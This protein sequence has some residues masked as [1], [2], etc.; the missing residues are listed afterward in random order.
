MLNIVCLRAGEAFAPAYVT[1][2]FDSVQRNLAKGFPYR[3][4]CF[5]D[6]PDE[7]PNH[8]ETAPLPADLP[9]WWSKLGLF[10]AGLFP[11]GDRILYLDLDTV[12]TGRLDEIAAYDGPFA[13][14]RDFYRPDGL[15]S[16]VMAWKAGIAADIWTKYEAAGC[17]TDDKDGDQA[18]IERRFFESVLT[19]E[20]RD[21]IPHRLQD[22][23]PGLFV[24]FKLDDL[25]RNPPEKAS[26][27]VFHGKPRPHEVTGWVQHVWCI[28][29]MSRSEL[30]SVCNTAKETLLNNVR[31]NNERDLPW[32]DTAPEH[33]GHVCIVGGGPSLTE[34][35]EELR[36]RQSVGQ[37][38]LALNG[39][40]QFLFVNDIVADAVVIADA[41]LE[42]RQFLT[43]IGAD[44]S[45]YL[46][47][48]CHPDTFDRAELSGIDVTLWHVNSEGMADLLKDEKARPVHLIGGGTTV[49]MNA[50]VLAFAS[51]FRKIHLY[52]FDSSFRDDHH[53]YS[54]P[55]NDS[56]RVIDALYGDQKFKTTAWMAQQIND[57]QELVPGLLADGCV[58]TVAG[59]GMLP[60]VAKDMAQHMPMTP[61]QVRAHE[62]LKRLNGAAEPRGVEVGVFAGD[63]SA[64]LLRAN[65]ILHLD[66]VDSWEGGGA[67]YIGDSGDY[68]AGLDDAVQEEHMRAAIER[69]AFA[70]DRVRVHRK[71]SLQAADRINYLSR[72]F[73]FID[74]DHSYEGCKAD[75]ETWALKVKPGGWI[76]G[77]DYE[78][79]A[80]PK[81]GVTRAVNEF[82]ADTG[83]QLELGENFTWFAK[84]PERK[85]L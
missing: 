61:A 55:A 14:L 26:V 49:G 46:A 84:I 68:H 8:I 40:A 62:V 39:A 43:R 20:E 29:G 18:W 70:A 80:F 6:R 27:V 50:I 66:M 30:D 45:A 64:A 1:I 4:V 24:S 67:A 37:K 41:R 44:T 77:H 59:D 7:L 21:R 9:K 10:R 32:F 54:Q 74:A 57:F 83:L 5:T 16:A 63:M 78:N 36:W 28:G 52:G 79:H 69:V 23:F 82:I 3:F 34:N 58:F 13:I 47:S 76:G 33:D 75:I 71:R 42:N 38:V 72:D 2:L 17:P 19:P 53:A 15:Q 73:V 56:D 31:E 48:Q 22:L 60:A 11:D 81:F 25:D 85:A 35:I 12:I 51:G 65:P